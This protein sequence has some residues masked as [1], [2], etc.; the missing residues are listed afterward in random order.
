MEQEVIQYEEKFLQA[1]RDTNIEAIRDLIHDRLIYNN[2]MGKVLTK[3]MDTDDFRASNPIIE[4]FECIERQIQLFG[5]TAILTTIVHLKGNFGGHQIDG[6][7]RF[8]R[9]WK[10]FE[11]GWKIIGAASVNLG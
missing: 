7:S 9:T 6:K 3:E 10:K 4:S 8:L 11:D 2:P 5:D 1:L